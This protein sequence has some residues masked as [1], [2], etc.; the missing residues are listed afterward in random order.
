[1]IMSAVAWFYRAIERPDGQWA[2][3]HGRIEYDNHLTVDAALQHL[4]E[5]APAGEAIA[6]YVHPLGARPQQVR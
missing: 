3:R 4:Q 6:L 1:M 2:C 5:L